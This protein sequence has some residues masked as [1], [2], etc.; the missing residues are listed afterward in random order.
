MSERETEQESLLSLFGM[1][2]EPEPKVIKKGGS[3]IKS[4]VKKNMEAG[5]KK[6]KA[7]AKSSIPATP[8]PKTWDA[9]KPVGKSVVVRLYGENIEFNDPSLLLED[10]R[11]MLEKDNPELT[12][13]VTHMYYDEPKGIVV[14]VVSLKPKG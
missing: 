12:K 9:N 4:E 5:G 2:D 1:A 10:I 14:P 6:S 8:T 3:D 7:A 11:K 13:E